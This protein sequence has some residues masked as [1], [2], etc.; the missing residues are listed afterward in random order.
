[1]RWLVPP[2]AGGIRVLIDVA[3]KMDDMIMIL[4]AGRVSISVEVSLGCKLNPFS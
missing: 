3:T 1:M 2:F 4:T